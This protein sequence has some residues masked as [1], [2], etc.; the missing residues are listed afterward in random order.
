MNNDNKPKD[1]GE[2]KDKD[3]KPEVYKVP[4]C[5]YWDSRRKVPKGMI[6]DYSAYKTPEC[7]HPEKWGCRGCEHSY[8]PELFDGGCKL[9]KWNNGTIPKDEHMMLLDEAYN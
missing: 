6:Q 1:K 3:K 4:Y 9:Y 2:E 7:V 5:P 8:Y